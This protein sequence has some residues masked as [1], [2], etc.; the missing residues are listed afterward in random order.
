GALPRA[1]QSRL[2]AAAQDA[3]ERAEE[4]P[5]WPRSDRGRRHRPAAP[6][7][8]VE[9]RRVRVDRALTP[10]GR[11]ANGECAARAAVVVGEVTEDVHDRVDELGRC[12]EQPRM[13]V[14][15]ER[16]LEFMSRFK[17]L[18]TRMVSPCIPRLRE[19]LLSAS[20]IRCR[21][22]PSI[23]FATHLRNSRTLSG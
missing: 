13:V 16:P 19:T 15:R 18:A 8:D 20:T 7:R 4:P 22:L 17:A 11:A 6:R 2:F 10:V 5:R 23:Q 9:R 14:I 21:W 12:L 1:G 3:V